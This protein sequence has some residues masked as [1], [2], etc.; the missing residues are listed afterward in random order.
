MNRIAKWLLAEK[1][2]KSLGFFAT[3]IA[4]L[5]A[6]SWTVLPLMARSETRR[7]ALAISAIRDRKTFAQ[8]EFFRPFKIATS[9]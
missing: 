6:A 9:G 1:N 5:S 4:A 7:P 8:T 3:G 2:R